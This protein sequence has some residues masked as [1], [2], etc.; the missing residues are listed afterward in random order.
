MS[1]VNFSR[2]ERVYIGSQT[3]LRTIPN[4]GGAWDTTT[5]KRLRHNKLAMTPLIGYQ[6]A[7][8]KSGSRA[9]L[10]GFTDRK[11]GTWSLTNQPAILSGTAG[12]RPDW[13]LLLQSLFG[14]DSTGNV[15][16]NV[17]AFNDSGEYPFVL[18]GF[19][20]SSA[21][22]THR[23]AW[24]CVVDEM[25][26]RFNGNVFDFDANGSVGYV[27]DSDNF[28]NEDTIAK[29]GLTTF[30]ADPAITT[31]VGN[32]QTGFTGT[33]TVD[34][35][36]I[37]GDMGNMTVRIQAGNVLIGDRYTDAY[38]S[39]VVGGARRV[40]MTMTMIDTDASTLTDIKAKAKSR[41]PVDAT[42]VIGNTAGYTATFALKK[43]VM[44]APVFD[45]GQVYVSLNLGDAT[46]HVSAMDQ[47]DDFTMTLS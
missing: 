39:R 19:F 20:T 26:F 1:T 17:Y 2:L 18:A 5:A 13:A 31:V 47:M 37:E 35:Q 27:L 10:Y 28:A 36:S 15:S 43:I 21:T 25:T 4:T 38:A 22:M 41:T 30:P 9:P 14:A 40:G 32:P 24:G 8:Y 29:A 16:N 11:G 7:P 46:A 34:G 33:V 6:D 12:T 23:V 45:D 3:T 44:A 42:I